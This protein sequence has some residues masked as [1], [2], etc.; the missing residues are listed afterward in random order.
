MQ[1]E[2]FFSSLLYD[3][4]VNMLF[5]FAYCFLNKKKIKF[6][7]YLVIV[8]RTRSESGPKHPDQV[9]KIKFGNS[10]PDLVLFSKIRIWILIT[11]ARVSLLV[12]G[13][14]LQNNFCRTNKKKEW[15]SHS[16]THIFK[17][18]LFHMDLKIIRASWCY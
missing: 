14:F 15:K 2:I 4:K 10:Y 11:E 16:R 12:L 1:N 3:L 8:S 6:I 17:P 9:L 13:I 5:M 7:F 18:V